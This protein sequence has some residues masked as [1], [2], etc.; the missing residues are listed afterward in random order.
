[1]KDW[2]GAQRIAR[3]DGIAL[4]YEDQDWT[5]FKLDRLV[6]VLCARLAGLGA[7][8]SS[9]VGV[10]L[11]NTPDYVILIHALARLGAVLL[12][13][14][15]R[16][17]AEEIEWQVTETG[18]EIVI[19]NSKTESTAAE[20]KSNTV[21]I[22]S[23]DQAQDP[24]VQSWW[25]ITMTDSW[26]PADQDLNAV[27]AIIFTSGTSGKP[28]GVQLTFSNHFYSAAA[29]AYRIGVLPEDRWLCTLPLYHVGGLAII[30][31]AAL[32][33]IA[34]VLQDGFNVNAVNT[35][36]DT[37][38]ITLMS[39]VPTM[40]YRLL[41]TRTAFPET[42]RLILLGGASATGDLLTRALDMGAPIAT[43]YG[44]TEAASQVA[45]MLP[46]DVAKKPG[47][48]GK[49]LM[50]TTVKIVDEQGRLCKAGEYGEI[51]VISP[52]VMR[53][54]LALE[55]DITE[56]HTGD[57]GFLDKDGDLWLINRRSDLIVSGGENVYPSE[58]EE[59]L[60]GHPAVADVVVVGITD[61]EWGQ[62]VAALVVPRPDTLIT[63]ADLMRYSRTKLAGYKQPRLIRFTDQLPLT[64]SGKVHRA[65]IVEQL[66]N[67]A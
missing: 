9:V 48:V 62:R 40:L 61:A 63:V 65:A 39:L 16:L 12:P 25:D 3:P 43:T 67:N 35:A 50:F 33:G 42:L 10:L 30:L 1:M 17:T 19:C 29:S 2:L 64:A 54:Y 11:S 52:M 38:Q 47:S 49:P 51:V 5:F 46:E 22:I 58:V 34:V 41:N 57:V 6:N 56:L 8:S 27:Q 66:Q 4:I 24:R 60:R 23:V 21:R 59:V 28:K 44:L 15:T 14:N 32:Y 55:Q 45:T 31:R 18:C 26:R 53:G 13:I 37:Q 7:A 20:L 36:L